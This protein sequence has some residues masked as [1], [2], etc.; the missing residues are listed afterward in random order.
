MHNE[1]P[2]TALVTG[3]YGAIGKAIATGLAEA[4]LRICLV[5]R[6]AER[7]AK[8]CEEVK[9][10]TGNPDV[11]GEVVELG[12]KKEIGALAAR[13]KGPLDLLINNAATAPRQRTETA[14]GIETQWG[15][16]VLSYGRMAVAMLPFMEGRRGARIVNVASYWA[17]GLNLEDPEFKTR[18]YDN[19]AAY[20]QAKQANRML[21]A[22]FARLLEP[23]GITVNSCHPGDVNSKLSNAFGF[24]GSESPE[25]GAATPL[26]L[27]LSTE[28]NG[29][30]GRYFEHR[31][32]V[33]CSFSKDAARVERL[34]GLCS[35]L[36]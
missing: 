31:R 26:F 22:T 23:E 33:A 9:H 10:K 36:F 7:L 28:V 12:S 14:E 29:M 11:F 25:E 15:V 30:T 1:N 21:S 34:Y 3:A 2:H 13:W 8:A 20:R 5:G 17:G 24:G 6:D 27:A 32:E 18:R 35:P 16:N 4:G 19:D